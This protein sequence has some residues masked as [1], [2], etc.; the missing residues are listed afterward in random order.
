MKKSYV[1]AL[2]LA[3]SLAGSVS[4]GYADEPM[5]SYCQL[6]PFIASTPEPNI[7]FLGDMSISMQDFAYC[8]ISVTTGTCPAATASP[9]A[10]DGNLGYEGYFDPT[11]K[12]VLVTSGTYNGVWQENGNATDC[13]FTNCT[14]SSPSTQKSCMT[15]ANA[16]TSCGTGGAFYEEYGSGLNQ[17]G[18][19]GSNNYGCCYNPPRTGDCTNSGD[20]F[21]Y[22]YMHR[23]DLLNWSITGGAPL[24]CN[25]SSTAVSFNGTSFSNT[26]YDPNYCDW[27]LWNQSGNST[28]IG[29]VCNNNINIDGAGTKTGGCIL[30]SYNA[31]KVCKKQP[32]TTCS[33]DSGCTGTC[34][35]TATCTS[36]KCSNNA[37]ISCTSNSQCYRCSN[38]A[39]LTCTAANY[40][41]V[42]A[43]TCSPK[44]AVAVPWARMQEGLA[45]QLSTLSVKPRLGIGFFGDSGLIGRK[46]YIGDYPCSGT[47]ATNC[48]P[49]ADA[50]FKYKNLI[51]YTNSLDPSYSTATGPAMTAALNYFQQS[52]SSAANGFYSQ[53]ASGLTPTP[54]YWRNPLFV[55]DNS[56]AN[57]APYPCASNYVVLLSDGGWNRGTSSAGCSNTVSG[58]EPVNPAYTMHK[59]GFTNPMNPSDASDNAATRVSAVYT[60]GMFMKNVCESATATT[61]TPCDDDTP[62]PSGQWC[63]GGAAAL[64]NIAMYGSFDTS[65]LTWPGGTSGY[66]T[67]QC[68][69]GGS[70]GDIAEGCRSSFPLTGSLCTALPSS[71]N[72]DWDKNAPV[73]GGLPDAYSSAKNASMIRQSI[74][75]A[76]LDILARVTSGTAASVLASGEGSGA[77]LI[78]AVFYP[79]YTAPNGSILWTGTLQNLWYY[80]DPFFA[81]N[82][83]REEHNG[84]TGD[85]KLNLSTDRIVTF[86]FDT[87]VTP[88]RTRAK[89]FNDSDGNGVPDS[90]TTPSA[91]VDIENVGNLWEAGKLLRDRNLDTTARR[92]YTTTT[93]AVDSQVDFS[94]VTN[95][96]LNVAAGA[97]TNLIRWVKGYD[98]TNY[99]LRTTT[100]SITSNGTNV[101]KLGDI[102]NSTAKIASWVPLNAYDKVYSD[103]TY[104]DYTGS[105]DYTGRGMV[106]VGANDGMLHA[107]KLG[108]LEFPNH[109]GNTCSFGTGDLACLANPDSDRGKEVWAFIP[110]NVLPYLKY[111]ADPDYCHIYSVDLTPFIFDASINGNADAA[112][113]ASSWRTII[114]GGMRTGGACR[115]LGSTCTDCVKTPVSDAGYSSY[116]ALDITDTLADPDV[117]PKLLWE[118]SDPELGFATTGP[119]PIR[120][121]DKDENGNWYVVFASGPTGPTSGPPDY[122]FYARSDQN[123][124][125]FVL[126]LRT[127]ELKRT[128]S[129]DGTGGNPNIPYAFAGTMY[130]GGLD[131]NLDYQDE[132][133]YVGY[134]K[135]TGATW[136]D[137]GVLRVLTRQTTPASWGVSTVRDGI[138][139]VTTSIARL[140]N[141]NTHE[142]W[143]YFGTGRYYYMGDDPGPT[144]RTDADIRKLYGIKDTCYTSTGFL[145]TCPTIG[146]LTDQTDSVTDVTNDGWYIRLGPADAGTGAGYYAERSVTNPSATTFR[147]CFLHHLSAR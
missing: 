23:T 8:D 124:K 133:F 90:P 41:T 128:I 147:R 36:G 46:V 74:K 72:T 138:G 52:N 35:T 51:A 103:P 143:L 73:A 70:V 109:T 127:G 146:S 125:L 82:S 37:S 50:T 88:P 58:A 120:I 21:N 134:V 19:S 33:N 60:V 29:V 53:S 126:D 65:S 112:K 31:P 66:P 76:V 104:S 34:S 121:G 98:V 55:C 56:G 14:S 39:T 114:I 26:G 68:K 83:I 107:F 117:Q 116:F 1:I 118:F 2:L 64:K 135:K 110:K 47:S 20:Y 93:G 96:L 131:V 48:N 38:D 95:T 62:C 111:L 44:I 18:C 89:L 67:G 99:R 42:C 49:T 12:Y 57:C 3:L 24:S 91:I 22:L 16:R 140:L 25:P 144:S 7:L 119:Q 43:D 69:S 15:Q 115:N 80:I 9:T 97:E 54:Q 130:Y 61:T 142:L 28:K 100:G 71:S 85:N 137:G 6:P 5:G 106:F 84:I 13:V 78:Q 75:T 123:L 79:S 40:T 105:S 129:M 81:N 139:P 63:V 113:S 17:L 30:Q 86:Y 59:T 27:E 4:A 32:A 92:I 45:Y 132:V 145:A 94:T 77:N 87:S 141:Q 122:K 136:T 101:L 10:Y 102:I 108:K 11:K